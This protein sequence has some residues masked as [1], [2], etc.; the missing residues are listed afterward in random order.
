MAKTIA[1]SDRAYKKAMA[2]K[3]E[4]E[5][6][7]NKVVHMAEAVDALLEEKETK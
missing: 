6:R 5:K 4:M 2:K 1:I 7:E 3:G